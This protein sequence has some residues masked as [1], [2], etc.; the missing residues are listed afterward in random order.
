MCKFHCSYYWSGHLWLGNLLTESIIDEG[1]PTNFF[2]RLFLQ[3]ATSRSFRTLGSI[4]EGDLP[5]KYSSTWKRVPRF[6]ARIFVLS[7]QDAVNSCTAGYRKDTSL[8][9]NKLIREKKEG[10]ASSNAPKSVLRSWVIRDGN[11][12]SYELLSSITICKSR[13]ASLKR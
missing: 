10:G 9:V 4:C 3:M 6:L 1:F 13:G 2:V 8:T 7:R 11:L 5:G 12:K